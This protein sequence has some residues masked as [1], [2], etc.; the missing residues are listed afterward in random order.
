V[1]GDGS[2]IPAPGVVP[3]TR[4]EVPAEDWAVSKARD[5]PHRRRIVGVLTVVLACAGGIAVL[6]VLV[7][8]RSARRR[9]TLVQSPAA[10]DAK[11]RRLLV[12]AA[13]SAIDLRRRP[14][15]GDRSGGGLAQAVR[16]LRRPPVPRAL[17]YVTVKRTNPR[18][19]D[20]FGH[21]WVE[22]DGVESYGW[23][24]DRCPIRVRDFFFGTSGAVNGLGGS[25][26]GG[27]AMTDPHHREPAQHAFHPTLVVR[28]SDRRVRRDLRAF[29][30]AFTG[31]WRYSTNPTSSD[32]RSFQLR[33]LSAADLEESTEH[34]HTRGTGCPFLAL[35]RTR[36]R[37]FAI[38]Q[39]AH[40][41]PA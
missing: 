31:E 19:G 10:P 29:A 33:L 16:S 15:R 9:T 40:T 13:L 18:V 24:P 36:I 2:S 17:T 38:G 27:T 3:E 32:C 20:T 14:P 30:Q 5:W 7:K 41:H 4:D 12:R 39:L 23:W 26:T 8:F 22:F 25:C 11:A 37:E 21:W 1:L 28:K 35:F 6:A 34:V